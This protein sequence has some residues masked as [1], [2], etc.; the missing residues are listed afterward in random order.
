MRRKTFL[1]SHRLENTSLVFVC[2]VFGCR[3]V[4]TGKQV[5]FRLTSRQHCPRALRLQVI[6]TPHS[7]WP[8]DLTSWLPEAFLCYQPLTNPANNRNF[9]FS[10]SIAFTNLIFVILLYFVWD[11]VSLYNP[12]WSETH[13]NLPPSGSQVPDFRH[14][15]PHPAK[16]I[17][18]VQQFPI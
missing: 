4:L 5:S 9:I 12:D 16:Y 17:C 8:Q 10:P 14:T 18:L 1:K 13:R 7:S 3:E 15:S 11:R 2:I 6:L